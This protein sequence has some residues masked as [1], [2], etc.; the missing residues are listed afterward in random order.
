MHMR[1]LAVLTAALASA[2][3]FADP[4]ADQLRQ[5]QAVATPSTV[6]VAFYIERDDGGRADIRALGTV[7]GDKGL[8][9]FSSLAVP[10]QIP[11]EQF[12][13]FQILV[14][15][16]TEVQTYA[17]DYLGK[18]DQAQVA[19]L[20]PT[21]AAK[22]PALP[23][24][25]FD[26]GATVQVGDPVV[27][28]GSLGEPDSYS[29]VVQNGRVAVRIEKPY[30]LFLVSSSLGTIGMPV[31]T[32]DGKAVGIVSITRL[33]RGTNAKPNWQNVEMI[34]PVAR[35]AERLKNPPQG[36]KAVRRP[37]LGVQAMTPVT[38]D[39]AEYLKLGDRR[40]IAIG[41]VI[42][43]GPG[44]KA[45][46]KSEDIILSMNGKA[47]A[48]AEGQLVETFANDLKEM[49][50]GQEVTLEVWRGGKT[51]TIKAK[52]ED[53]PKGAG[54]AERYV[55]RKFGLGVR[56]MVLEDRLSR[57]LPTDTSGV[58]VSFL[59]PAGWA[60]DG[61]LQPGDIV[62]KVQD[63]EVKTL[64]DFKKVFDAEVAK[65][66]KEIVLFVLRG[67]TETQIIR[68]EPRWE[69]EKPKTETEPAKTP[70]KPAEEKKP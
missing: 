25:K 65:K 48:G 67:K 29:L 54:E 59:E 34:W 55:I 66:P 20:R 36:G 12:K 44:D 50:I 19:F 53:M 23:I 32:L 57:E 1:I 61:G 35:F 27:S 17:A 10:S 13:D 46:L 68:I 26:E 42:E 58:V 30:P 47:I 33:N 52:L 11:V 40:G 37:W 9:M 7:V 62:K 3:A 38:K 39:L 60:Q 16:G 69:A 51:V 41:Q 56:E 18:D 45:G 5:V 8:V 4:M 43:K 15:K 21:E 2:P 63:Q 64:A 28:F 31:F 6:I 24:L 14:P 22:A 70:E 49:A